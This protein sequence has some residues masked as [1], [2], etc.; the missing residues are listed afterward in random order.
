MTRVGREYDGVTFLGGGC[1]VASADESHLF[2]R[3]ARLHVERALFQKFL[4]GFTLYIHWNLLLMM[5]FIYDRIIIVAF[6]T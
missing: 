5:F 4:I 2:V 1:D 3:E 6:M